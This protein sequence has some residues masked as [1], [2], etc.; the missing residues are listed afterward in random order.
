MQ[1][2]LQSA[3][4]MPLQEGTRRVAPDTVQTAPAGDQWRT[5]LFPQSVQM[6]SRSQCRNRGGSVPD[7]HRTLF[8]IATIIGLGERST[9]YRWCL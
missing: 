4:L 5:F 3:P 9:H 2:A 1:N 6:P 8:L 7:C